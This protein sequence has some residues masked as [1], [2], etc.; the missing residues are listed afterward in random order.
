MATIPKMNVIVKSVAGDSNIYQKHR[1]FF[2]P[3]NKA[4][5]T[6]HYHTALLAEHFKNM[7]ISNL[8]NLFEDS[9]SAAI[10]SVIS[11]LEALTLNNVY[12]AVYVSYCESYCKREN[13]RY[14][15][16]ATDILCE[17]ICTILLKQFSPAYISDNRDNIH[18]CI[19]NALPRDIFKI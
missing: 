4:L 5:T 10:K 1:I 2:D 7:V 17:S 12:E 15:E 18:E 16:I 11:D 3:E 6:R 14:A 8:Y 9:S 19:I 13:Y